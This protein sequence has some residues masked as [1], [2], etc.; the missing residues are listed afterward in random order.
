MQIELSFLASKAI[1]NLKV[2]EVK[3]PSIFIENNHF[4]AKNH[5]NQGALALLLP[6]K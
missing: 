1:K 6:I 5:K 4:F 2:L 3:N